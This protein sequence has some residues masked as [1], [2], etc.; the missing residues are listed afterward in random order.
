MRVL[1]RDPLLL[2]SKEAPA[3]KLHRPNV[4]ALLADGH[5]IQH[6]PEQVRRRGQVTTRR[7]G[8][9][10]RPAEPD[11]GR[12]SPQFLCESVRALSCWAAGVP[13][14]RCYGN[15]LISSHRIRR[16]HECGR[17][18]NPSGDEGR[19]ARAARVC[20]PIK[21]DERAA[22]AGAATVRLLPCVECKGY[23]MEHFFLFTDG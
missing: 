22:R 7:S 20:H 16:I 2:N 14:G 10:E 19:V 18:T 5:T 9:A 1:A 21:L 15:S 3:R 23:L 8:R 17:R 4:V 13:G 12:D 6:P 11:A